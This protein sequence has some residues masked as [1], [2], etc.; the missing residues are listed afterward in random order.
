MLGWESN[1]PTAGASRVARH[2]WMGT[3]TTV[4]E[5]NDRPQ[6]PIPAVIHSSQVNLLPLPEPDSLL[7][8]YIYITTVKIVMA[9]HQKLYIIA[10]LA[11][12]KVVAVIAKFF[13]GHLT[14]KT[15]RRELN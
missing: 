3:P 13:L 5:P 11:L 2:T 10:N 8:G 9:I 4:S 14:L 12:I 1:A 6:A 15:L 7:V